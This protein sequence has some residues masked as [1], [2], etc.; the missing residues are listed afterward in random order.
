MSTGFNISIPLAVVAWAVATATGSTSNVADSGATVRASTIDSMG[1]ERRRDTD[2]LTALT[3]AFLESSQQ[4]HKAMI[5]EHLKPLYD[6]YLAKYRIAPDILASRSYA[7]PEPREGTDL[8]DYL[9]RQFIVIN[10][11]DIRTE[12]VPGHPSDGKRHRLVVV[13]YATGLG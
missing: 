13:E 7:L 1:D 2:S 12:R 4:S 5:Y 3:Y 9:D 8:E 10:D 11:R 6:S